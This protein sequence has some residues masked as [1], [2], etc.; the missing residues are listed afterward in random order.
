MPV[1]KISS[2][3]L[4]GLHYKTNAQSAEDAVKKLLLDYSINALFVK[5]K[6]Y[7]LIIEG[8][9]IMISYYLKD[10]IAITS[11]EYFENKQNKTLNTEQSFSKI[12]GNNLIEEDYSIPRYPALRIIAFIYK[13]LAL[14]SGLVAFVFTIW[15]FRLLD[16]N[17]GAG[18]AIIMLSILFGFI[19]VLT[20]LAASEL[21]YLF[22]NTEENTRKTYQAVKKD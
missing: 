4:D 21:I 7:R 10:G 12:L 9:D 5:G 18:W 16:F 19:F 8:A 17:E 20:L 13:I 1:L 6:N 22:I 15:G 2:P 3:D 11:E 14:L